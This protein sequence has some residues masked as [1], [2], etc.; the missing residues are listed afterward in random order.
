M[1]RKALLALAVAT[2]LLP[3]GPARAAEDE[4]EPDAAT[5]F[6][7]NDGE[8]G[9][10]TLTV[11]VV[12]PS[13]SRSATDVTMKIAGDC[14]FTTIGKPNTNKTYVVAVAHATSSN[15]SIHGAPVSTG[16]TCRVKNAKGG[17]DIETA[18]PLTT[19]AAAQQA[20]VT[21]GEFTICIRVSVHYANNYF[22]KSKEVCR[23]PV[24]P[25]SGDL[26]V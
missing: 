7:R 1:A 15:H 12:V 18:A 2:A 23:P 17:V 11:N 22:A 8:S 3:G 24:R 16:V 14:E 10:Q 9:F 6:G 21:Y 4:I 26:P 13:P 20:E 25:A 5:T 19:A